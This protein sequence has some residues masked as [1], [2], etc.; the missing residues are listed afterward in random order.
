MSAVASCDEMIDRSGRVRGHWAPL[1]EAVRDVGHEELARRAAALNRQMR[2]AAPFGAAP[3]RHYD[4]LPA[5]LTPFEFSGLE[6]GLLQ[7]AQLLS[8][9]LQDLYGPQTL[10]RDGSLPPALVLG[11]PHFLRSLHTQTPLNFPRLSLYAADLIRGPD[12][13]FQVLRDHTGVIPGLGHALSLRRIA[14][15][16]VPELFRAGGLRSLRPVREMLVDNL[17][18]A[19]QGGLVAVLSAGAANPA[20]APDAMDDA[21]LARALG[22]LLIE[23]GD[24]ATRNGGLHMKTLSGLLPVA[25]LIRGLPGIDLDPLEQGGRPGAGIPGA[26]GAIRSGAL[27]MLNAP[28]SALMEA[29]ELAGYIEPLFQRL[30]GAAP[31]L[32]KAS[33]DPVASASRAPFVSG[34]SL[35]SPP[36]L[37]RLYAWHDGNTWQV[38]PGGLGFGLEQTNAAQGIILTGMKDLWVL[39]ADEPHIISGAAQSDVPRRTQFLAA[40]HLPSR[41]ADNLFWLGRSVER[42]EAAARLLMLALPRLESG[43]SLPR[44]LAERA[45]IAK[46]LAQAGLLPADLAGGA[47]SGRQLRGALARRKPVTGQLKEVARLVNAASERLSPSMLATVRFALNQATESLPNEELALPAML[48][49]AATFAGIAAENMSR[50]GGWLFLEMGR[51][52]ERAET[53]AENLAILLNAPPERLEPGMALGIEL[54]DSVLSYDLRHAGILAPGPVL[55]ML[56]ADSGNPR[57]LAYQ[58]IV[59]RSCLQH[60]GAEDDAESLKQLQQEAVNL[61]GETIGL[62]KPLAAIAAR[63]RLISDH[64]H[65]RFFSLLPEAHQ[66]EDELELE[67]AQ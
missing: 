30:L 50:D 53:L 31:L 44:D 62:A 13:H 38:L 49:F 8:A 11:N 34:T 64:V 24:L 10:L 56:L 46:C 58:F 65:R 52:L 40:A 26:F 9:A 15:G 54:A 17:Q 67:A 4:P 19:A 22:V 55:S 42:L 29:A 39:D 12:G 27:K 2:L 18:R 20:L 63:L 33:G 1:L 25:S 5:L 7:R 66:L 3:T 61:S 28:G 35:V 36:I 47:L 41:V 32:A 6:A 23:P 16:T 60:L 21:L 43:T 37:F 59:L 51:R 45:L 57:S 14:S 48:S